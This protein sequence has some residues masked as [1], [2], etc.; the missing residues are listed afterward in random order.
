[1]K[2]GRNFNLCENLK[3]L[4]KFGSEIGQLRR[5]LR[6]DRLLM[7]LREYTAFYKKERLSK[8]DKFMVLFK[9]MILFGDANDILA[10]LLHLRVL[11][12]EKIIP[13]LKR[14]VANIYFLECIGWLIYHSYEY[15]RSK[16]EES[17]YK[18][19]MMMIKYVLDTFTSHNDFSQRLFTANPKII[20]T[21]GF[22]SS[23]LN[24]Y[25]VWK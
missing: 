16:D 10:Y 13:S 14:N 12:N 2:C 9:A 6:C 22:I 20:S 5:L 19:K 25:L 24:L 8:V 18:N 11:K 17:R 4:E 1:M 7:I 21:I 23:L 3:G 15:I